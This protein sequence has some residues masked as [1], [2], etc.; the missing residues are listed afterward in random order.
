MD[1]VVEPPQRLGDGRVVCVLFDVGTYQV[2]E[3]LEFNFLGLAFG[4][5]PLD[6]ALRLPV[7]GRVGLGSR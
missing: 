2:E 3:G 7:V 6:L 1:Q 4:V 5:D